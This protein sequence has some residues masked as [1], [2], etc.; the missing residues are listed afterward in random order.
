MSGT[1]EISN[2]HCWMPAG[3]VYDNAMERLAAVIQ[4]RNTTLS[5]MLTE[6]RTSEQG[7]HLDL[8]GLSVSELS[9]LVDASGEVCRL[10]ALQGPNSFADPTFF[11]GFLSQLHQLHEMLKAAV[12]GMQG[13]EKK[14]G[15]RKRDML[16]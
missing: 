10:A 13:G 11:S 3:W 4:S 2:T 7:G 5:R 1:L 9:L 8:R 15:S 6:S 12:L 16:K 14:K